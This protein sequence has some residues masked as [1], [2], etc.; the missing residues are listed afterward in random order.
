MSKYESI[1]ET[2]QKT[3][4]KNG[5]EIQALEKENRRLQARVIH[6]QGVAARMSV[7]ADKN[8]KR[9][10]ELQSEHLWIKAILVPLIEGLN[11]RI[12]TSFDTSNLVACGLR[13]D[14]T[15]W[16]RLKDGTLL[17]LTFTIDMDTGATLYLD[18]GERTPGPT[19]TI[20]SMNGLY[21]CTEKVTGYKTLIENLE[22][23]YP[24]KFKNGKFHGE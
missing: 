13:P 9:I 4:S 8:Q 3:V 19:W 7:R 23:R 20:A 21:N 24:D 5:E 12:G 17:S 6:Y 10:S 11:K 15:T 2:Y 16:Q 14:V 22:R 1:L 18:T